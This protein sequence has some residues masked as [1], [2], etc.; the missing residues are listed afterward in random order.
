MY[1]KFIDNLQFKKKSKIK[2]F[3]VACVLFL[4][5]NCLQLLC[6]RSTFCMDYIFMFDVQRSNSTNF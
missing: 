1:R 5:K 4:N 3:L 2:I 6:L